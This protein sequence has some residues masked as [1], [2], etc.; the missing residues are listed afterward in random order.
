MVRF[1]ES[2]YEHV[3]EFKHFHI[4]KLET[5]SCPPSSDSDLCSSLEVHV[6][7][8]GCVY[9]GHMQGCS[10]L[11]STL[12]LFPVRQQQPGPRDELPCVPLGFL[13]LVV[14]CKH[15]NILLMSCSLTRFALYVLIFPHSA[16]LISDL[17]CN[18]RRRRESGVHSGLHS[19]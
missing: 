6:S 4:P 11:R 19:F 1:N 17:R 3:D 5:G 13:F 8:L 2:L 7:L 10:H 15:T 16:G 18:F 9:F 14:M 12:Y